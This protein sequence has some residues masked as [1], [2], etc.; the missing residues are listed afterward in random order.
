MTNEIEPPDLWPGGSFLCNAE[1]GSHRDDFGNFDSARPVGHHRAVG[2]D[3]FGGFNRY[4]DV[5]ATDL[6]LPIVCFGP[7][8]TSN[9]PAEP[10]RN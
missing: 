6:V 1:V 3:G 8:V 2:S 5:A 7:I 9:R 10:S 4:V